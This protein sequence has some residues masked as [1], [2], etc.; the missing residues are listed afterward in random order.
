[1]NVTI[2]GLNASGNSLTISNTTVS[3]TA[4]TSTIRF[5]EGATLNTVTNCTVRGS[6]TMA[7][8]TAGGTILFSTSTIVGGNSNN[9]ISN[10]NIGPA[11]AT[12]PTK[13]VHS[14]GTAAN[15]NSTNTI[16]GCNIFDYTSTGVLVSAT[17]AGNGW[18]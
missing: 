8:G 11:G 18:T 4:S 6:A 12:L 17:G 7:V 9:T 10:C 5:R 16:S 1:D 14:L 15:P 3:A 13:G 2:N